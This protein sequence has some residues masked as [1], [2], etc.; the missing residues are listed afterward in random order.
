MILEKSLGVDPSAAFDYR[1]ACHTANPL[2]AKTLQ[3][4][5]ANGRTWVF[6]WVQFVA[7]E[8]RAETAGETL[9]LMFSSAEI[10]IDGTGLSPLFRA[11]A[12]FRLS[13]VRVL[14]P[15]RRAGMPAYAPII[16]RISVRE[17]SMS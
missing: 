11:V 17:S 7:V 10:V 12:E 6:P 14:P 2:D 16:G 4:H 8:H 3:V 15:E 13:L 5:G 9:R 1:S